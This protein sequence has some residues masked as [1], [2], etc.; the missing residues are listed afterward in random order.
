LEPTENNTGRSV[1][2]KSGS[3]CAKTAPTGQRKCS[4]RLA[5]LAMGD[6]KFV[7]G[8][9]NAGA[10]ML[11]ATLGGVL[12]MF[13]TCGI[14]FLAASA[15]SIIGLIEGI[16]YLTKTDEEF[17]RIYVDGRKEWF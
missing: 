9:N 4:R 1:P 14:T 15:M 3:G 13:F 6:H 10:L 17:V 11:G 16:I 8:Y 2:N 7:L 5:A 12:L